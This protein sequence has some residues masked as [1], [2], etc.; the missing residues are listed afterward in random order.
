MLP[1]NEF[2]EASQEKPVGFVREFLQFLSENKKWWLLPIIVVL[3]LCC[4]LL[5]I[6]TAIAPYIYTLY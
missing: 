1:K 6:A 4:S 2:E 3:A 5:A